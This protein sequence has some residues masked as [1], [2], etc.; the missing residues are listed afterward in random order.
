MFGVFRMKNHDFT[1]KKSYFFQILGGA[2]AGYAPPGSSLVN[3]FLNAIKH[4]LQILDILF[5]QFSFITRK[6]VYIKGIW[7][8]H[9]SI[10]NMPDTCY[11]RNGSYLLNLIS[12]FLTLSFNYQ[13]S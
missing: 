11:S 8:S 1:Q 9:L 13:L 7:L 10:L 5:R 2:R 6:Y 3:V 4:R 12:R